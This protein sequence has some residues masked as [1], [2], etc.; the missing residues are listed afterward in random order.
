MCARICPAMALT[1][2]AVVAL[3]A[4]LQAADGCCAY[5][6]CHAPCEKICRLVC[7]EK[8]VEI[9]CW[10]CKCEDFC[11][12]G[13]GKPGCKHCEVVCA[14]CNE[15]CDAPRAKP[16]NF[17]WTEWIPG[18]AHLHTKRKLMK[19]VVTKQVPSYKW[20]VEELCGQCDAR[21]M[22]ANIPFDAAVPLPPIVDAKM[23]YGETRIAPVSREMPVP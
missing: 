3:A 20:V 11:L 9:I 17:F 16:K 14:E 1:L 21:C 23:K 13:H 8:T 5:C 2:V 6:G 15:G 4:E 7:E 18:C 10:G 22:G 19:K 12:P